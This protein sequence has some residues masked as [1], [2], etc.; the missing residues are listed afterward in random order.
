MLI[1]K[2]RLSHGLIASSINDMFAGMGFVRSSNPLLLHGSDGEEPG[3]SQIKY[4]NNRLTKS[5][6][7]LE[8]M[9]NVISA[10]TARI[11]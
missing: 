1:V 2:M 7:V 9:V 11:T 10:N 6:K 3:C 8:K 5:G 4:S